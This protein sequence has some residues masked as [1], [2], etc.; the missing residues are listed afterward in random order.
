MK[1]TVIRRGMFVR[2]TIIAI[3]IAAAFCVSSPALAMHTGG[4]TG[5][6]IMN[7]AGGGVGRTVTP[8]TI[9]GR[10]HGWS[11]NVP[12]RANSTWERGY[13]HGHGRFRHHR[14]VTYRFGGPNFDYGVDSCWTYNGWR[15]V[16]V[17]T[18]YRD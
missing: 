12:S 4:G 18:D 1:N 3:R 16:Y 14:F 13:D 10:I 7:H 15:W 6:T 11:G 9:N 2:S 17:C 5:P 8:P